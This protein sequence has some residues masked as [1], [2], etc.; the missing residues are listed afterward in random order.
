MTALAPV[1]FGIVEQ[2]HGFRLIFWILFAQSGLFTVILIFFVRETRAPV[3]LSRKAAR[4]RK[5]TGSQ[6][7]RARSD[8]ERASLRVML[9]HSLTRPIQMLI[10]EPVIIAFSLYAAVAWAAVSDLTKPP[11][12]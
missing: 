5:E 8:L 12:D 10:F 1:M 7:Y 11:P 6:R 2:T 3:L 4:L 9:Y